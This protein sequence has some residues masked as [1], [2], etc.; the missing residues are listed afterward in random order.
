MSAGIALP[1]QVFGHGF[2]LNRGEKMSKSVGNVVDPIA[3]AERYGVDQLRYFLLREVSFGQD[4]SYGH[5]AIVNRANAELANSFGNL[6]QRTLSMISKNLEGELPAIDRNVDDAAL[7]RTVAAAC[8]DE[9]PRAF[10]QLAFSVGIE[11]WM[12]AVF[13]CNQ[14]ITVQEP[15]ALRKT[16]PERMKA[17][18]GNLFMLIRD[19]AIAIAPVIPES[20][21]KLLDQMGIAAEKRDF[22][23]L[24]DQSWYDQLRLS[25]Y[26][27][28][29]P[30]PL[31]PKLELELAED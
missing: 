10:E 2:L 17:V 22:A 16:D 25:D 24:E 8:L 7:V 21:G 29:P 13:A 20:I 9:T 23:A 31:Y 19:L 15:W 26:R 3:M 11:A 30:S 27:V 6:I 5:E 4:G 1:K 18:L 28:G 12:K 14:Y